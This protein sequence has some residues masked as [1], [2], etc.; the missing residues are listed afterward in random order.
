VVADE[1]VEVAA[2]EPVE[3]T[4][5]VD[6]EAADPCAHAQDAAEGPAD[7]DEGGAPVECAPVGGPTME[8]V[9]EDTPEDDGEA[10]LGDAPEVDAEDHTEDDSQAP[11]E[12]EEDDGGP[13][14][15]G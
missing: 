13:G 7:G 2:S 4:P 3:D 15:D 5:E 11:V 8:P 14:F 9:V 6:K 10:E 1:D 12:E